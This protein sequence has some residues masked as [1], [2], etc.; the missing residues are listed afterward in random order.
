MSS[1][2]TNFYKTPSKIYELGLSSSEIIVLTYLLSLSNNKFTYPSKKTIAIKIKLSKRTVD[3]SINSLVIK[4][5][6]EYSRGFSK[7]GMNVSNQYRVIIEKIDP[8]CS[9]KNLKQTKKEVI[10]ESKCLEMIRESLERYI[11]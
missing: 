8:Y 5:F 3:R 10:D 9:I 11:S 1:I 4:G 2:H 6:L 7:N